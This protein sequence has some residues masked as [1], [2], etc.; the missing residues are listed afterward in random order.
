MHI[1]TEQL[2]NKHIRN[3]KQPLFF[4]KW[5]KVGKNHVQD[6]WNDG[7]ILCQQRIVQDN[8]NYAGLT[9]EYNAVINT[10]SVEW[11]LNCRTTIQED[12]QLKGT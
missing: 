5:A 1:Y 10:I 7:S 4:K 8:A 3:K 2:W 9:F 12:K 11:K 6:L